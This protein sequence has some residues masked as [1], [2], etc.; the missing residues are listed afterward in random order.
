MPLGCI[1]MSL[2]ALNFHFNVPSHVVVLIAIG[3][4]CLIVF[5]GR[6]LKNEKSSGEWRNE[7][8]LPW[9]KDILLWIILIHFIIMM[10]FVTFGNSSTVKATG[11]HEEIGNCIDKVPVPVSP[12][13]TLYKRKFLCLKDYDEP[14]NFKCVNDKLPKNGEN[15]YTACGLSY[16]NEYEHMTVVYSYCLLGLFV[17]LSILRGGKNSSK[18]KKE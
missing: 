9:Y 14:F 16:A 13:L 11:L 17:Y 5:C 1:Q 18:K 8:K 7:S 6:N 4:Y 12:F 2:N 10:G 15:W 3:I